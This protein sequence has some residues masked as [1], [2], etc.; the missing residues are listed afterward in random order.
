MFINNKHVLYV[1]DLLHLIDNV[2]TLTP[3][4]SYPNLNS[5]PNSHPNPNSNP[6]PKTQLCFSTDE[7]KSFFDQM[8]VPIPICL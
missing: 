3:A 5:N 4:S 8:Y 1:T 2:F 6:N 7:M